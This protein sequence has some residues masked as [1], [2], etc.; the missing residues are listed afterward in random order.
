MRER[1]TYIVQPSGA[2]WAV[3]LKDETLGVF[4]LRPE[5]IEAAVVVAEA[6]GRAGRTSGVVS[7][8]NGELLPLWQVGRD[9]YSPRV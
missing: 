8:Q 6:S 3:C 7:E 9:A 4:E 5:A 1:D 2:G